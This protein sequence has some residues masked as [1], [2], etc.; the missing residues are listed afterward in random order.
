M[1][2]WERYFFFDTLKVLLFLLCAFSALY[3][4]IDYASHTGT[5]HQN[6]IRF[7]I[8]EFFI[9]YGGELIQKSDVILPFGIL[10]ATIRV[11]TKLNTNNELVALLAA[12]IQLKRLLRP[13]IYIG[14][15]GVA[16]L[17]LSEELLSPWLISSARSIGEK[18]A[19]DQS[20][21][22]ENPAAHRVQLEDGTLLL[23]QT[24]NR[25]D[26]RFY[27]VWWIPSVNELWRIKTLDILPS[28]IGREVENFKRD[29]TLAVV[30]TG[31]VPERTFPEIRFNQK[32]LLESLTRPED[33]ALSE[34]ATK[35]TTE[36]SSEKEAR[37]ETAFWRKLFMPWLALF[38]VLGPAPLCLVFSRNLN[39]F[40]IYAVSM[41]GLVFVY[42][43]LNASTTLAYRQI[44]T[45]LLSL[46]IPF[47]ALSLLLTWRWIRI[48]N[49]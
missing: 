12:G 28:V 26:Q 18:H 1:K 32:R 43:L 48:K 2:I 39:T 31:R 3:V 37:V 24:Y 34:L 9:Y 36:V 6:H 33:L 25:I 10:V 11:L 7:S 29:T 15:L 17:Y 35:L 16:F 27:D 23:F 14:L 42:I 41:F 47:S 30:S 38:A 5:F 40:F 8:K 13:F 20:S 21:K 44:F 46:L 4:L 49:M 22:L 45:P 19:G